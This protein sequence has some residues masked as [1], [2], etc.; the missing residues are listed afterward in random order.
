M[1][2]MWSLLSFSAGVRR[3]PFSIAIIVLLAAQY[4]LIV[5]LFRLSNQP[6]AFD[7]RFWLAPLRSVVNLRNGSDVLDLAALALTLIVAWLYGALAFCRASDAG[8]SPWVS[9]P[10]IV[11][12][13]QLPAFL[14][15]AVVPSRAAP[16]MP[17]VP[18]L[19][20]SM[21][22]ILQGIVAGF[23]VTLFAV[24]VG[25]LVF[26]SYGY[27]ILIL[28]PFVIGAVTAYLAN[29]TGDI[30]F[31]RTVRAVVAATLLGAAGLV[32][33]ALEGV[34]CIVLAA[35]LASLAAI[36]GALFGYGAAQSAQRRRASHSLLG[37][38]MLPMAFASEHVLPPITHFE[39]A[40]SIVVAAPP[41]LV[42][43]AVVD[44][45]TLKEPVALPF[46]LGVAYPVRATILGRGVG[47]IRLGVF[48][49]GVARERITVWSPGRELA[50]AVLDSPPAM[51]EMSP[52]HTVHAPH[53]RGYFTTLETRFVLEP[54]PGGK[55]RIVEHTEH[56]LK[57]EPVLYWMPLARLIVHE[58][59][60]RVLTH[61]KSQ[62]ER[63]AGI[64]SKGL[65]T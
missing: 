27:G 58:N 44:M 42:W 14:V 20:D 56:V 18:H 6:L 62:A 47:A 41:G 55:T 50:F 5:L 23:A 13:L 57:L 32:I 9:A 4:G 17:E 10:A 49:T 34:V 26:G 31:A 64:S 21:P 53:I 40:E 59:N 7:W 30:G 24:A 11:P 28:S 43:Q 19:S 29:R 61:I 22:A 38:A 16:A 35:P 54:L 15:L 12:G 65:R 3:L 60:A 39:T 51:H 52:Y 63:A 45:G 36:V 48:S 8:V 25:A 37:V 46:R 33:F 2:G 1:T